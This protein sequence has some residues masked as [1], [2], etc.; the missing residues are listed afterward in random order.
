MAAWATTQKVTTTTP[1]PPCPYPASTALE[2]TTLIPPSESEAPASLA[3][4]SAQHV[5]PTTCARAGSAR[6]GT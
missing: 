5:S 6:E 4:R 1:S 2:P 3:S